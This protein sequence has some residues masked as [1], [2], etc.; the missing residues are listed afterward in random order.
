MMLGYAQAHWLVIVLFLLAAILLNAASFIKLGGLV[1]AS[2]FKATLVSASLVALILFF[3][4]PSLT[5]SSLAFMGYWLDWTL[6]VI[7]ALGYTLAALVLIHP[8]VRLIK[9]V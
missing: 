4:I 8:L 3:A 9:H 2:A 5:G 7:M 6:L 1:S